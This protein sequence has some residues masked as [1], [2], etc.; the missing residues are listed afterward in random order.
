MPKRQADIII[1]VDDYQ[2]KLRA[3]EWSCFLPAP[4]CSR[5]A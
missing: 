2:T 1:G 4:G 5:R 3:T